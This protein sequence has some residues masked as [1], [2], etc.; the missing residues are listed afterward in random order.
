MPDVPAG[1]RGDY[2]ASIGVP[3]AGE[4]FGVGGELRMCSEVE[5]DDLSE[6]LGLLA[7]P[8]WTVR[9]VCVDTGGVYFV[10]LGD[11]R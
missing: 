5:M 4:E 7:V 6:L 1:E 10:D 3:P 9:E 11:P 8:D 2:P